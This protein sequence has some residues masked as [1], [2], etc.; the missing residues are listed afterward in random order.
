MAYF[1]HGMTSSRE[2][3]LTRM[4]RMFETPFDRRARSLRSEVEALRA[5]SDEDLAAMGIR[6][7][8]ILF[9]VFSSRPA[10]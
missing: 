6:R 2:T 3:L 4:R 8:D 5:A 1:D 10:R 7:E 9:H